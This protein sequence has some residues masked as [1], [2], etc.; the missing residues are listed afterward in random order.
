[1]AEPK[2]TPTK[3]HQI[4]DILFDTTHMNKSELDVIEVQE[5]SSAPISRDPFA[6]I[7]RVVSLR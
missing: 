3:P 6:I 1:M 4:S 5:A 7:E 2:T